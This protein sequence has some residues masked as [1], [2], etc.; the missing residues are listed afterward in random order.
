[1]ARCAFGRFYFLKVSGQ[2]EGAQR[3]YNRKGVREWA[4]WACPITASVT[5]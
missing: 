1:V 4:L 5:I 3:A 2:A